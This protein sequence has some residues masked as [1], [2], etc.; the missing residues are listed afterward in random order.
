MNHCTY[1]ADQALTRPI[2]QMRFRDTVLAERRG[3][4]GKG[5]VFY[6]AKVTCVMYFE[7]LYDDNPIKNKPLQDDIPHPDSLC[8]KF[9]RT[10]VFQLKRTQVVDPAS[11]NRVASRDRRRLGPIKQFWGNNKSSKRISAAIAIRHLQEHGTS[12]QQLF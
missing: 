10:A 6:F 8:L 3:T 9:G 2:G 4:N 12:L 11:N 1:D 5:S 7:I